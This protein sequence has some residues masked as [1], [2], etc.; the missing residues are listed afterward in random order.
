MMKRVVDIE[1]TASGKRKRGDRTPLHRD[2]LR[3]WVSGSLFGRGA[4][5]LY[6]A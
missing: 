5:A 3:A 6:G 4:L 1:V 2:R